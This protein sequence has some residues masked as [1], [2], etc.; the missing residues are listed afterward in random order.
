VTDLRRL[1]VSLTKHNAH[2]IARLLK[3]YPAS[4]VFDRL[5]EVRAEKAQARKNLSVLAGDALPPVWARTQALG[6][7]AIDALVMVAIVFSHTDLIEAMSG[8]SQRQGFTGRIERSKQ[9]EGKA[10]TNFVRII[11]QLGFATKVDS[12]GI[13][14]NLKGMFRISGLGPLVSQLLELKL[15][16]ARWD[17]ANTV[18]EESTKLGFQRVFGI[19]AKEMRSWFT[20]DAQPSDARPSITAKDE[21][22]FQEEGEGP[23]ESPFEFKPGHIDRD[24]EPLTR[25]ASPKSKAN[26]L[27]NEIQNKLYGH[28]KKLLGPK[29]VGTE[30]ETG[31]GTA[32]DLATYKN[33]RMT[34]YEI[35]TGSSVRASIRQAIPQL[36]EYAFWPEAQRADELVIVSH[37]PATGAARMYIAHLGKK[38]SIP[39]SYRQFDLVSGTLK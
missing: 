1:K 23:P 7:D 32:V 34:F 37:L 27:H 15:L 2:K 22:Y 28:L 19:S 9:L 29:C 6:A 13:T 20:L 18:S 3:D 26:R 35:K 5:D 25:A 4:E 16:D 21:E 39:L 24:V 30:L 38:F 36:L 33:G 10:Y 14:F 8:A 12:A 11:D 17:R 31:T